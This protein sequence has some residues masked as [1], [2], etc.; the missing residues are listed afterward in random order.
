[1]RV[2][3]CRI[4]AVAI[5]GISGAG[6]PCAK[7]SRS[8]T[9]PLRRKRYATIEKEPDSPLSLPPASPRR[10][11]LLMCASPLSSIAAIRGKFPAL[12]SCNA[13]S[14]NTPPRRTRSPD[15]SEEGLGL[16][17]IEAP[18]GKDADCCGSEAAGRPRFRRNTLPRVN[19]PAEGSG[20]VSGR[21]RALVGNRCIAPG[22]G[23]QRVSI[24]RQSS[25]RK[26]TSVPAASAA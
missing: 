22:T 20:N 21:I 12:N 7:N 18:A 1:M 26:P 17:A 6:F 10:A 16:P 5:A 13:R 2:V 14:R 3:R 8:P 4:H 11:G 24:M 19:T 15:F 23:A 25:Q 9:P